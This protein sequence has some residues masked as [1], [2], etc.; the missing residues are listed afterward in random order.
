MRRNVCRAVAR[1]AVI[2]LAVVGING[3]QTTDEGPSLNIFSGGDYNLFWDQGDHLKELVAAGKHE[4]AAK[5]FAAHTAFFEKESRKY[6]PD[7]RLAANA[8]NSERAQSLAAARAK[9]GLVTWPA[10]PERW[11]AVRDALK[12]AEQVEA[13]Y[14]AIALIADPRF[15]SSELTAL[16]RITGELKTLLHSGAGT[17]FAAFDHFGGV[18][19]FNAYPIEVDTAIVLGDGFRKIER[20]LAEASPAQIVAFADLY[21]KSILGEERWRSIG[22]HYVAALLRETGNRDGSM[23]L[24]AGLRAV[25]EARD[26]GFEPRAVPGLEIGIVEV[27]SRTLLKHGQ[28]EFPAEIHVDLPGKVTKADLDQ[29]LEND[30][31]QASDYIIVLDVA[32]AKVRRRVTSKRSVSSKFLAGY[33]KKPNPQYAI[34]QNA[35]TQAQMNL[36]S[37]NMQSAAANAQFC[38]GMGCLGKAIGQI[39]HAIAIDTAKQKAQEAIDTLQTTPM[40][41]DVPVFQDYSFDRA[42]VKGT[43][44]MTVHYYVI[45]RKQ[46][47]Y[48]KST[49]DVEEKRTFDVAYAVHEKDP[50][51]Q[52]HLEKGDTEEQVANWEAAPSTVRLTQL[53][54]HYLADAASAQKIVS[55][56]NLR[57]QMLRDKNEA[58]AKYETSR[59]D[60]RPLN[61]ARFDHVVVIYNRAGSSL[62]SGFFVQPDVVLTNAH[63][64]D[65]A[66]FVEMKMYDGQ[67]TFGKVLAQ[68][69]RLDLALV[70]VQ[71]RGKPVHFY[72]SRSLDLGKTVEVIG[73]PKGL[74]FSIT[75]GVISAVRPQKTVHLKGG[76]GKEVL[77]I[78]TDAPV[79][80]GNSGGPLFLN[81][82]V[83]GVNT[84]GMN[85]SIAEGLNFAVHYSEVMEFLRENLPGYSVAGT[86]G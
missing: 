73:H 69:V 71:R 52:S 80:P 14:T 9:V 61:D 23:D 46:Q 55:L 78:Q 2:N 49:F 15:R 64:V 21:P 24:R 58:L 38:Q 34:A 41:I 60:A 17:A 25:A 40:T 39:G 83:V 82:R 84:Q 54:D 19:F 3:C 81:D 75:R 70:R 33:R 4:D 67:E 28:I 1:L 18:D 27:T 37:A 20:S 48:F 8:L 30:T 50:D 16:R 53:V 6:E 51:G 76:G 79:N 29:A 45:E 13:E 57:G 31:A 36:Q 65:Q 86:G 35:L 42:V 62:G 77:F 44:L 26:A 22:K 47:R 56:A 74:E 11:P 12:G 5:L 66:R 85:K 72:T 7:L 63:V 43:K 10:K 68:D 32:L 59:F